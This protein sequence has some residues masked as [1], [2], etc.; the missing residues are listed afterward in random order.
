V[1]IG[2]VL[3]DH[4]GIKSFRSAKLYTTKKFEVADIEAIG[5]WKAISHVV[6]HNYLYVEIETDN[7]RIGE[8]LNDKLYPRSDKDVDNDFWSTISLCCELIRNK[9]IKVRLILRELN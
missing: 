3:F 1:F 6:Q 2:F 4:R 5:V 8:A 7:L 9:D